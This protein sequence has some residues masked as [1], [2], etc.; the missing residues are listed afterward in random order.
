MCKSNKNLIIINAT[1]V[2]EAIRNM[3]EDFSNF[4]IRD[5]AS[6]SF[7]KNLKKIKENKKINEA[8][9]C[10]LYKH[11]SKCLSSRE[12]EKLISIALAINP[13]ISIAEYMESKKRAI[14]YSWLIKQWIEMNFFVTIDSLGLI[15]VS[16]RP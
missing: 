15:K 12:D 4:P 2:I 7:E 9:A 13:S 10:I 5:Q 14:K 11:V 16:Y 1:E 6:I 8:N 3:H